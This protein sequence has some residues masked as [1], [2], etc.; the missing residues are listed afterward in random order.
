MCAQVALHLPLFELT[1]DMVLARPVLLSNRGMVILSF[2]AG[3]ALTEAHL[4]QLAAHHAEYA[5]V[6]VSVAPEE[7]PQRRRALDA[8]KA[9]VEAL[10]RNASRE[11][12]ATEAF[13][14]HLLS[15][16]TQACL[17]A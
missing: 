10:F 4:A 16:R 17:L 8:Q 12:P 11:D 7:T 1:V 13:F 5:C 15:F 2:P 14:T 3:Q 9:R 6:W